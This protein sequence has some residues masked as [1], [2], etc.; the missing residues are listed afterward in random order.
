MI[1][2][3]RPSMQFPKRD[4]KSSLKN[5][6]LGFCG[7]GTFECISDIYFE[8]NEYYLGEEAKIRV[9]CDNSACEKPIEAFEF[10]L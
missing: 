8:K 4:F 6:F 7:K 1:Y 2:I 10:K 9:I 5:K 3:Q